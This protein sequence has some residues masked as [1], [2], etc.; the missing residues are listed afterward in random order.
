MGVPGVIIVASVGLALAATAIDRRPLP[1]DKEGICWRMQERI[2]CGL[3]GRMK[4]RET[5]RRDVLMEDRSIVNNWTVT[6]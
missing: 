1:M 2:C 6:L 5:R 4:G 3:E